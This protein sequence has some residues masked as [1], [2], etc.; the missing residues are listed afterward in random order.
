MADLELIHIVLIGLS[1]ITASLVSY[2]IIT[3]KIRFKMK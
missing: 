1:V 3:R 2:G